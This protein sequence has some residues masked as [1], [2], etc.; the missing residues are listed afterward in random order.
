MNDFESVASYI[1]EKA[2]AAEG[3]KVKF[4]SPQVPGP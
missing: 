4:V 2:F 1:S 3:K